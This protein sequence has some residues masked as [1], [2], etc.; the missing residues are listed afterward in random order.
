MSFRAAVVSS[1]E[2]QHYP[3]PANHV[4]IYDFFF[5][6]SPHHLDKYVSGAFLCSRARTQKPQSSIH[7]AQRTWA[8]PLLV[9][10]GEAQQEGKGAATRVLWPLGRA[11]HVGLVTWMGLKWACH[12]WH[13]CCASRQ[14]ATECQRQ[15]GQKMTNVPHIQSMVTKSKQNHAL[16]NL[17]K[18]ILVY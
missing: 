15:K 5:P 4:S 1:A 2:S 12:S 10:N 14:A 18:S 7:R 17:S 13:T 6:S 3:I 8:L 16:Q 9:Y 11:S